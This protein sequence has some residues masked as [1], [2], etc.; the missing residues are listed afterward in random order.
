[1]SATTHCML[2]TSNFIPHQV[3]YHPEPLR[4]IQCGFTFSVNAHCSALFAPCVAVIVRAPNSTAG[5]GG[6]SRC[7]P[8]G[9]PHAG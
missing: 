8:V 9:R 3:S 6:K 7:T 2:M 1:M 5:S 4:L